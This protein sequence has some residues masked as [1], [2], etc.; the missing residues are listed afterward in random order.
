MAKNRKNQSAAVHFGSV[1][2][3]L[4]LCSLFCG[5][6]VGYVWQKNEI[7]E[8]G[9]QIR[10]REMCLAQLQS[11]DQKLSDQLSMLRSPVTL[12]Q[13]AQ[14]LNLGLGPT[15]PSQI[16]RLAEPLSENKNSTRQFAIK[17]TGVVAQE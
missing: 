16:L 11:E 9:R 13:R 4:V 3:V 14:E 8:L 12:D 6:A 17:Q 15:Q 10:Q 5:S 7:Y 2:K 1:L